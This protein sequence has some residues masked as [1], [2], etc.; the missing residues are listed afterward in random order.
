MEDVKDHVSK[1][2]TEEVEESTESEESTKESESSEVDYEAELSKLR[3]ERDRYKDLNRKTSGALAEER[4]RRKELE[5][6]SEKDDFPEVDGK[7]KEILSKYEQERTADVIE[8]VLESLT[9]NPK[10]QELIRDI[11]END[12]K[13]TGLTKRAIKNDLQK[14]MVLADRNLYESA[15]KK[16]L[17]KSE[18]Q[19]KALETAKGDISGGKPETKLS[20][21]QYSSREKAFLQKFGVKV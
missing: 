5:G 20:S 19:K 13:P 15:Q 10:K 2:E 12:L 11:Y 6:S 1:E 16:Q 4:R 7:I 8:D 14:A 21:K 9:D 18:A 3:E 17:E